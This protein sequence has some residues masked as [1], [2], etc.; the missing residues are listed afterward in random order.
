MITVGGNTGAEYENDMDCEWTIQASAGTTI[1][2]TFTYLD[3]EFE[4]SG[5]GFDYV[6]L[7][8]NDSSLG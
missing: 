4:H 7:E 3:I 6:Q 8:E 2:F 5:C 1:T